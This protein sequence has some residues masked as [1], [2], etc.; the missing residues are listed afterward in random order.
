MNFKL[1]IKNLKTAH[2]VLVF[3]GIIIAYI[4][5]WNLWKHLGNSFSEGLKNKEDEDKDSFKDNEKD[6]NKKK[7]TEAMEISENP[8]EDEKTINRKKKI[9]VTKEAIKN[10]DED[11]LEKKIDKL[12]TI[13]EKFS[14]VKEKFDKAMEK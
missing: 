2:I 11:E 10:V 13:T 6:D 7:T 8:E 5:L 4:I 14:N 12:V 3:I 9:E 1:N